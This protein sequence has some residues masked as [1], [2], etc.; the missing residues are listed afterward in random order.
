MSSNGKYLIDIIKRQKLIM[1]NSH[2]LC[3]GTIT[4]QRQ[5]ENKKEESVIDFM[6]L[7]EDLEAY[8]L[9][10]TI[11]EERKNSFR[12][13]KTKTGNKLLIVTTTCIPLISL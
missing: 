9:G 5:F 12:C 1:C 6:L 13:I 10:M 3:K 11:D 2:S 8:F 7:C 4:R